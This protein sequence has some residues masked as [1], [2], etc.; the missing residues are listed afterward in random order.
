MLGFCR[1][2][3]YFSEL[4]QKAQ[5]TRAATM[6][7]KLGTLISVGPRRQLL[8]LQ[9]IVQLGRA[10]WLL[11]QHGWASVSA[12]LGTM[13]AA[14]D[15]P[16]LQAPI[17][18]ADLTAARLARDVG[19]AVGAIA[20][21]M[22]FR[23]KCLEQAIA[24]HA[25]LNVRGIGAFTYFGVSTVSGEIEAHAWLDAVGIRVIGYP[26]PRDYVAISCFVPATCSAL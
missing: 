26:V 4:E 10:R 22:P 23:A 21:F 7:R 15:V 2:A 3:R 24:A 16:A 14:L 11:R 12:R 17:S 1:L 6:T 9:A 13:I 18:V 8:V 25:M 5:M 19:W 20:R